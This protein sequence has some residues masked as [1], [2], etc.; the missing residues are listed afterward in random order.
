MTIKHNK[1]HHNK[2]LELQYWLITDGT[3]SEGIVL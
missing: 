2:T 3:H 1:R